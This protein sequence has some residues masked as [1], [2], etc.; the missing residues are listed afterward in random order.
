M[1]HN[2]L[3]YIGRKEGMAPGAYEAMLRARKVSFVDQLGWDLPEYDGSEFETDKFD[4]P[5]TE[6]VEVY[7]NNVLRYTA[8][9]LPR[10]QSMVA[11]LWPDML[12][13]IPRRTVEISRFVSHIEGDV[14]DAREAIDMFVLMLN[15]MGYERFFA[16]ADRRILI[17][18]RRILQI[19]PDTVEVF[20][21]YDGIFLA[22]WDNSQ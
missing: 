5:E 20:E 9:L 14:A 7:S 15:G 12:P 10:D 11:T 18:Y 8:R 4:T 6:Y 17:Y 1:R 13:S 2:N 22:Q 16:I 3:V 19:A 21:G